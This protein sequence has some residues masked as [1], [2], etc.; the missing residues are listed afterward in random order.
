MDEKKEEKQEE[1]EDL[2]NTDVITKYRKAADITNDA[3]RYVMEQCV[4]GKKISEVCQLGDQFILDQT[5]KVFKNKKMEKG[6]GFPTCISVDNV[7][8]H[9]SPLPEEDQ[10]LIEGGLVKIDLGTHIDGYVAVG[11][12]SFFLQDSKVVTQGRKADVLAACHTAAECCLRLLKPGNNNTQ[13]T[14]IIDKVA[15]DF[16]VNAVQGV[17]SHEMTRYVVDGDKVILNRSDP[18]QKVDTFDFA[19]NE[20]YAIDIVMSTGEGIP[21]ESEERTTVYKRAVE[22]TY[23]LKMKAS[24]QVL[25][26]I[27][28]RFPTFPFTLR[29]LDEKKTRFGI[30]E[31]YNHELCHAYPVL[32]EKEGETV[33]HLKFTALILNSGTIRVTGLPVDVSKLETTM[34]ISDPEIT[35]VLQMSTGK[36]KKKKAKKK[37]KPAAAAE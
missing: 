36:K 2:S 25:A 18:E 12:H 29:A 22:N 20:V 10:E 21:R 26:E 7:V 3:L 28:R 30:V 8:S 19:P 4:P 13:L 1:V 24:R 14:D 9:F 15:K 23:N 31:I 5:A 37:K 17:L 27:N 34:Q 33:A 11:A 35:R 16:K 6:V 32:Y